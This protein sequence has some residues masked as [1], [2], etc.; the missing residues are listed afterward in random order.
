MVTGQIPQGQGIR[1]WF[2][3]VSCHLTCPQGLAEPPS[4]DRPGWR[5]PGLAKSCQGPE[6][7]PGVGASYRVRCHPEGSC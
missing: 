5:G 7:H 3:A 6:G 4:W 2:M 1:S